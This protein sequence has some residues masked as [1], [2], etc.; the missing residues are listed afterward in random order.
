MH[1]FAAMA[2]GKCFKRGVCTSCYILIQ[3][4]STYSLR[5]QCCPDSHG[6]W[7]AGSLMGWEIC[8][9]LIHP[10]SPIVKFPNHKP[11]SGSKSGYAPFLPCCQVGARPYPLPPQGSV[12]AG[13]HLLSPL[14]AELGHAPLSP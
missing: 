4:C 9:Q 14:P 1:K 8:W 2:K 13:P 11:C 5:D 7:P 10:L 6:T 12:E 3:G